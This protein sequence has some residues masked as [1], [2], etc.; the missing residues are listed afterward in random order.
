MGE[1]IRHCLN[2]VAQRLTECGLPSMSVVIDEAR[3]NCEPCR[4]R[5]IER[6]VGDYFQRHDLDRKYNVKG[7]SR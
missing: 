7:K 6:G 3:T 5:S 1:S 2:P 4:N